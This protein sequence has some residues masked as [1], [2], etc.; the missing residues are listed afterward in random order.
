MTPNK[1]STPILATPANGERILVCPH[2]DQYPAHSLSWLTIEPPQKVEL[3]GHIFAA[4]HIAFCKHCI[5]IHRHSYFGG[6]TGS[7]VWEDMPPTTP[8]PPATPPAA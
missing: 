1:F 2:V 8:V 3:G 4:R 7:R 6:V 5:R